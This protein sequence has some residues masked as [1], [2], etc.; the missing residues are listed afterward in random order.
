VARISLGLQDSI[1]LGNLDAKR[2]WGFAGDYVDAMWRMLQADE[3]DDYVVATGETHS[4]REYLD[5]AFARVG[6]D[7]WS[8][9]VYVDPKF[10]RPAEVDLL[11]G[12]ATKVRERLGWQPTVSFAELVTMM[13]DS[14]LSEQRTLSG[15]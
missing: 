1:S 2:D 9:L 8:K 12:D 10:F 15:K 14:D 13:V 7:D 3:A 5:I 11:I 6:I 4:I